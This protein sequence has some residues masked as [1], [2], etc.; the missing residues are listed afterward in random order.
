MT[1]PL[2]ERL[3]R[4]LEGERREIEQLTAGELETLAENSRCV[5]RNALTIERDTVEATGRMSE[6][7]VKAWLRS[8]IDGLSLWLESFGGS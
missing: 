2:T 3:R 5:A 4:R 1:W 7:L 8:L 6:L